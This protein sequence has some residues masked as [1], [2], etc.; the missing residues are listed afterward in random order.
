MQVTEAEKWRGGGKGSEGREGV[1]GGREGG[2][3]DK[4]VWK[5]GGTNTCNK[6]WQD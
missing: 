2:R 4:F 3:E 1:R 5:G 6:I